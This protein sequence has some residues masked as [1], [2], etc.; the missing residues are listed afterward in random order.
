[1]QITLLTFK[2]A[3]KDEVVELDL[4]PDR[5]REAMGSEYVTFAGKTYRQSEIGSGVFTSIR[6][7]DLGDAP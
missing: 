1:M 6:P 4:T 5:H 7:L 2:A 3:V